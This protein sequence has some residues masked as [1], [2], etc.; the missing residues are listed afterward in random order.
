MSQY[1]LFYRFFELLS[2]GDWENLYKEFGYDINTGKSIADW[3]L[4]NKEGFNAEDYVN[5]LIKRI[6]KAV[7]K[8]DMSK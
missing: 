3:L 2:K 5:G 4:E 6:S 7:F 8:G 1:H